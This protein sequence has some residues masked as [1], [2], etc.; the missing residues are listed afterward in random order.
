MKKEIMNG[1][2]HW[3]NYLTESDYAVFYRKGTI[4]DIA[5]PPPALD[6]NQE[7]REVKVQVAPVLRTSQHEP[8]DPQ[9]QSGKK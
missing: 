8:E 9:S 2:C 4:H 5:L 3:V 1:K 6:P 7:V